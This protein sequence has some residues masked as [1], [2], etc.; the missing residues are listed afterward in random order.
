MVVDV[1]IMVPVVEER[2]ME[3]A[4]IVWVLPPLSNSR[5]TI[6]RWLCLALSRTPNIALAPNP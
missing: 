5:I 3:T 6:I 4:V 2:E 1:V